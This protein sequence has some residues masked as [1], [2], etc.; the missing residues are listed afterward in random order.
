[1]TQK[2]NFIK[3]LNDVKVEDLGGWTLV[4]GNNSKKQPCFLAFK[5]RAQKPFARFAFLTEAKRNDYASQQIAWIEKDIQKK[6]ALQVLQKQYDVKEHYQ[7]GD[8]I[9][10]SWGYEQTNIEFYQ[11]VGFKGRTKIV[12]KAIAQIQVQDS[13]MSHG[14][15]CDVVPV[16]DNFL[17]GNWAKEYTLTVKPKEWAPE[18]SICNPQSY[19][20]FKKWDGRAMYKSWY[21]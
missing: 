4:Y 8:I 6:A 5:P 16:K 21:Y 3:I 10:N 17:S 11:V 15:A 19:Y 7:I 9:Y 20:Y 12:V 2:E 14:M 1:M 13:M 18:G